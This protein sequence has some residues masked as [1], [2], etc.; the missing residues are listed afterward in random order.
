V[1]GGRRRRGHPPAHPDPAIADDRR[2]LRRP[3]RGWAAGVELVY[4][5]IAAELIALSPHPLADHTVLGAGAGTGAASRAWPPARPIAM[6][7]SF[8]MLARDAAAR[9]PGAV[10]DI[11]AL[12][13][14]ARSVDDAVAAFVLHH[15]TDPSAGLAELARV[16]RPRRR[17]AGRFQHHQR[18]PGAGPD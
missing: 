17:R 3:G 4:G 9:P 14:A 7:L 5:P 15:L 18:R 8:G 16:T 12:P 10:A 1:G 11:R 6:D 13:L 2:P